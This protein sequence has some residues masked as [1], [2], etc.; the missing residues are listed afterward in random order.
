MSATLP[1]L[2]FRLP[3][4]FL[5]EREGLVE[6]LYARLVMYLESNGRHANIVTVCRQARAHRARAHK[7]AAPRDIFFMWE[8]D[9]LLALG[10]ATSAWRVYRRWLRLHP[11]GLAAKSLKDRARRQPGIVQ[12]REV[13]IL[14]ACRKWEPG[15]RAL[16]AYLAARL[17]AARLTRHGTAYDLLY[18]IYNGDR[19]PRNTSRVTL[20][21]FYAMLR[22]P[23]T[24]WN[25]WER[26]VKALHPNLFLVTGIRRS[27]LIANAEL[28]PLFQERL[29]Q[30]RKR[31]TGSSGISFGQRDLVEGSAKVK[32]RHE[33]EN[34][35]LE[36]WRE[37]PNPFRDELDSR[38]KTYFPFAVRG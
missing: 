20:S 4:L 35:R 38:M 3:N 25:D 8:I 6:R 15:A 24:A 14:Y 16:E 36:Q 11:R 33:R 17:D 32:R 30:E 34:E 28:L 1:S 37:R 7:R 27:D 13:P 10:K 31:R 21:H 5:L 23:L 18:S 12:F 9:A 29:A 22:K 2:T 19:V 26:W